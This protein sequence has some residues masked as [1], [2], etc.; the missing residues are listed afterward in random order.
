MS[1]SEEKVASLKIDALKDIE[2]VK[3]KE[4]NNAGIIPKHPCRVLFSGQTGSGK[5]N[6]MISMLTRPE[7]YKGYFK[8]ILII[9]PNIDS[10]KNYMH[11]KKHHDDQLKLP[12][13]KRINYMFY[14][15][16]EPDAMDALMAYRMQAVEKGVRTPFLIILDDILEH[17]PLL[18]S[19]FLQALVTRGRHLSISVFIATQSYM[20]I[21]RTIRLNC[22]DV[23]WYMPRNVGELKRV[24]DELVRDMTM[25]TFTELTNAV[26][27]K[28]YTFLQF[29]IGRAPDKY[30]SINYDYFVV[31][32]V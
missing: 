30:M 1:K 26:F 25:D 11:L 9:S 5:S 4:N 20:R 27:S 32:Q 14:R 21:P 29:R 8:H 22:S 16:Y 17:K 23:I 18:N 31:K 13:R 7:F 2:E 24:Y 3:I 28:P 6:L 15:T 19:S 12:P 10:D